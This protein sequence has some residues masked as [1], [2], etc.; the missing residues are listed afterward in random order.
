MGLQPINVAR[1]IESAAR[2]ASGRLRGVDERLPRHWRSE[3]WDVEIEIFVIGVDHHKKTLVDVA[4]AARSEE[5]AGR[6]AQNIP[7]RQ[8]NRIVPILVGRLFTRWSNPGDV[9]D[10]GL[11]E[12]LPAKKARAREHAMAPAK[13]DQIADETAEILVF[14]SD[15]L[16][17]EPR[18]LVVLTIR[19]VVAAL[20]PADLVAGEQHRNA[21][22]RKS[23]RLN[24]S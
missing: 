23:T 11:G 22:D 14:G 12:H 4:L 5:F 18:D 21:E 24:S 2:N 19:V 3:R 6:P 17:V 16:P 13:V 9:F 7:K 10:T 15:M 20:S 8:R 1:D